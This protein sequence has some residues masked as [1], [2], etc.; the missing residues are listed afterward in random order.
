M[1]TSQ[2]ISDMLTHWY[3]IAM[4]S[5][6][7]PVKARVHIQFRILCSNKVNGILRIMSCSNVTQICILLTNA[8]TNFIQLQQKSLKTVKNTF[9][10]QSRLD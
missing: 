5:K 1:Y 2:L 3:K 8:R 10:S 9:T 4:I 6:I 7:F